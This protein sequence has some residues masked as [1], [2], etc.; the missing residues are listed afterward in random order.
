MN[1]TVVALVAVVVLV[2]F[3]VVHH[4][5]LAKVKVDLEEV[6]ARLRSSTKL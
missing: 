1:L 3:A 6:L 2:G 5:T 4:V